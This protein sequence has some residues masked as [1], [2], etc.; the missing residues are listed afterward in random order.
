MITLDYY[1]WQIAIRG[2][3]K[4]RYF[5]SDVFI[6]FPKIITVWLMTIP[7]SSSSA[8]DAK[9]KRIFAT[10]GLRMEKQM[11]KSLTVRVQCLET[12]S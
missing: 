9:R 7:T 3:D 6:D 8:R 4:S 1:D 2:A 5:H 10:N 11:L 12:L